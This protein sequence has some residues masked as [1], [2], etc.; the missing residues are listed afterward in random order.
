MD[1][2]MNDRIHPL[3][4]RRLYCLKRHREHD[5]LRAV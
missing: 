5:H 3:E 1:I 4:N 2:I